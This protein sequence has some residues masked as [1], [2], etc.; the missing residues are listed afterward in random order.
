VKLSRRSFVLAAA[1]G[2]VATLAA[3]QISRPKRETKPGTKPAGQA[4]SAHA[5]KYYRTAKI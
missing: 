5:L 2:G 4:L 1:A 3:G